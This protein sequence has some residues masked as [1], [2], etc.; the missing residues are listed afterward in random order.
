MGLGGTSSVQ[1]FS[2]FLIPDQLDS[3]HLSSLPLITKLSLQP[4]TCSKGSSCAF[5]QILNSMIP[6]LWGAQCESKQHKGERLAIKTEGGAIRR[7]H[8]EAKHEHINTAE[9]AEFM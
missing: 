2:K 9:T 4:F 3:N 5:L 6:I 8:K 1:T 7:V